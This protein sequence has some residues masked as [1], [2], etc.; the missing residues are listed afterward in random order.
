MKRIIKTFLA[1]MILVVAFSGVAFAIPFTNVKTLNITLNTLENTSWQHATP[2]DFE[3]PYDTVN[4]ASITITASYA[5]LDLGLEDDFV[6]VDG[7]C[8]GT[9]NTETRHWEWDWFNSGWVIDDPNSTTT[10]NVAG[11]L[12]EG[13]S[14]GDP[15]SVSVFAIEGFCGSLRLNTSTFNL[16]YDNGTAPV[17]E[18][19][20]LL[21]LGSGLVGLAGFRRRKS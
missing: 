9:L 16:D 10:F 19:A 4:S 11:I 12:E 8:V 7:T 20:T 15:L 17:P 6:W 3:V 13:W 5:S 21:L 1:A 2:S 18:P 14:A